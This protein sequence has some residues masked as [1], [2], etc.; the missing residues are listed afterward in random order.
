MS[1]GPGIHRSLVV[2]RQYLQTIC[3]LTELD[4]PGAENPHFCHIGGVAERLKAPVLKT[5]S[6]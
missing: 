3:K 6:G 1:S 4:S 5:G 2:P